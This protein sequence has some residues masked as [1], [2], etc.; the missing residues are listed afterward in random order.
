MPR[1][2]GDGYLYADAGLVVPIYEQALPDNI[3]LVREG[4]RYKEINIVGTCIGGIGERENLVGILAEAPSL[5][6][7]GIESTVKFVAE[8][9]LYSGI[10]ESVGIV[11]T[12]VDTSL[13]R[14]YAQYMKRLLEK[15][16]IPILQVAYGDR[17]RVEADLEREMLVAFD[18]RYPLS[19]RVEVPIRR[20]LN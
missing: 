11:S 4:I 9:I 3:A 5:S 12:A 1:R 2:T 15:R 16:G 10:K 19:T 20:I 8:C 17:D 7:S 18:S 13:T 14:E 6:E